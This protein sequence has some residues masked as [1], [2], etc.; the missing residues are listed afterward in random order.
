ML[1]KRSFQLITLVTIILVSS[2][3]FGQSG[4]RGEVKG[5]IIDQESGNPV[6][7]SVTVFIE[8]ANVGAGSNLVGNYEIDGVPVGWYDITYSS[9][10]YK[11]KTLKNVRVGF[12]KAT[13]VDVE[14][15]R[16]SHSGA[17]LT[18]V[19]IK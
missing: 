18:A 17:D 11:T 15:E 3:L 10:G 19:T 8:G 12:A 7:V 4:P 1:S 9:F 14:M 16:V 5:E 2:L 6:Y 13:N